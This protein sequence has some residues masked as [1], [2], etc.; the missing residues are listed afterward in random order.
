MRKPKC[1]CSAVTATVNRDVIVRYPHHCTHC[2]CCTYSSS[3]GSHQTRREP[4]NCRNTVGVTGFEPAASSSRTKRATKLRHTPW[5]TA[6][7]MVQAAKQETSRASVPAPNRVGPQPPAGL[8]V[9]VNRVTSG[10]QAN[11]TGAYGEVP[12][13]AE[14]SSHAAPVGA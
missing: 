11:R 14:T 6:C 13:P 9:R 8:A 10:R 12:S 4:L 3:R 1:R 2:Y 5:H 7:I